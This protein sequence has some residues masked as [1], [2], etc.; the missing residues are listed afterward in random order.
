M[1]APPCAAPGVG[2]PTGAEPTARPRTRAI[3]SH[4]WTAVPLTVFR[5]RVRRRR[6]QDG[7]PRS[8][9]YCG[10][11]MLN[12]FLTVDTELWPLTPQWRDTRLER[13]MEHYIHG[14]ARE[15]RYGLR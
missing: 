8:T 3:S 4:R 2:K 9:G 14:V 13:E 11:A 12:V 7:A 6:N 1:P 5:V 15:G 10:K